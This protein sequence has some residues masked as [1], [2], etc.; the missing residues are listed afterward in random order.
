MQTQYLLTGQGWPS[1]VLLLLFGGTLFV[2]GLH[3]LAAGVVAAARRL[4]PGLS[5]YLGF[6][7]V[8]DGPWQASPRHIALQRYRPVLL[9]ST[10]LGAFLCA[11]AVFQ[12]PLS[13]YPHLWPAVFI[14]LAYSLPFLSGRRL[15][16]LSYLKIFL[17]AP[18]WA[19]LTVVLPASELGLHGSSVLFMFVERACFIF[20][21]ALPFDIR[22]QALDHSL[23][24]RTL[25]MALGRRGTRAL[26]VASLVLAAAAAAFNLYGG[27]YGPATCLAL[28]L[29]FALTYAIVHLA[30]PH[31][32][33]A[34]FTGLADG[35]LLLQPLL[36]VSTLG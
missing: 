4:F 2:Y 27:A 17:I 14:A 13:L 34:Y 9:L 19:W 32:P 22:D 30:H 3:R 20:A 21:L 11:L 18:V 6:T 23:G 35:V 5:D 28:L 1:P 10:V 8:Q 15:R 24:V 29:T 36:V 16:D 33:D 26:A 25:P 7:V 31:R 12:L